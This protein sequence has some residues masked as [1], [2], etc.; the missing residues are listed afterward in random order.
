SLRRNLPA[1][2]SGMYSDTPRTS[3][4]NSTVS[5]VATGQHPHRQGGYGGFGYSNRGCHPHGGAGKSGKGDMGSNR[6][7]NSYFN[8]INHLRSNYANSFER[9]RREEDDDDRPVSMAVNKVDRVHWYFKGNARTHNT[10]RYDLIHDQKEAKPILRR[11]QE[12]YVALRFRDRDFD[13]KRDR[14]CLHFRFGPKPCVQKGTLAVITV[15]N[16]KFT[17]SKYDWDVRIDSGSRGK[18]LVM[19]VFVPASAPVGIWRL[20]VVC[21][22]QHHPNALTMNTNALNQRSSTNIHTIST[23]TMDPK[24]SHPMNHHSMDTPSMDSPSMSTHPSNKTTVTSNRKMQ[25]DAHM[26]H[27]KGFNYEDYNDEGLWYVYSDH[28]DVYILFNPWCF[29]DNVYMED[30]MK[31]EEYVMNDYGKVY[32]GAYRRCRGRPWAFGQFDDVVLPVACYILDLAHI[33]D[34]DRGNSVQV[35]KAISSVVN[36]FHEG[37]IMEGRWDGEYNDGVA[38]Y[39]WTGT[40]SILEEYMQS[41]YRPVKYGQCWIFSALFTS[42]CRTLGIPCRSVTNYVSAHDTNATL[43][44]DKFFD[45]EGSY[46]EGGPNGENWDS[47]WNFHAWNDVWMRRYD[48]PKGFDGWQAVDSTPQ[49]EC[50]KKEQC[51]PVSLEALRKGEIGYNYD[52]SFMYSQINS[53]IMHWGEDLEYDWGWRRMKI[54]RYRVGRAILTKQVGRDDDCGDADK[55]DIL[56]EYR[57]REG[58]DSERWTIQSHIRGSKRGQEYHDF[59][60][61]IND[62]CR[63]D[64]FELDKIEVG[65]PFTIR[66]VVRNDSAEHRTVTATLNAHSVYYTGVHHSQLKK[67]E[68]KFQLG[69]KQQQEV[70]LTLN[71]AEYWKKLVEGCMIKTYAICRVQETGQT[72]TEEEDY[73]LDKPKLEIKIPKEVKMDQQCQITFTFKNP[74]DMPLT[75]CC[76]SVDGAGI[77]R[78][79]KFNIEGDIAPHGQFSHTMKFK[80][81]VHGDRKIIASFSSKEIYDIFGGKKFIVMKK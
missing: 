47:V 26:A 5:L 1:G 43:S 12:F 15:W 69:P 30:E 22:L 57:N 31:R 14:I 46:F 36:D 6:R 60:S 74:L 71:C 77:M 56:K 11:G 58:S 70:I 27:M 7:G 55:E 9:R 44:I 76:L 17:R 59:K 53:D 37:G 4:Y 72:F 35:V 2:S 49:E 61:D 16:D 79:R 32:M 33:T 24:S 73:V 19:Q 25:S 50:D 75:E 67:A 65:D 29:D 48:L 38:P 66:V 3:N 41:G 28:T 13:V 78:P 8:W 68:G 34:T 18:D 62:D 52:G 20:D 42:I 45:K 64:L 81:L 40:V 23:N 51:G 80:P 39:K 21:G 10:I 54:N 63:F